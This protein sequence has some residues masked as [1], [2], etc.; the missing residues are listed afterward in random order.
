[1]AIPHRNPKGGKLLLAGCLAPGPP[2]RNNAAK[3]AAGNQPPGALCLRKSRSEKNLGRPV[4]LNGR[5][6][7]CKEERNGSAL[8]G[9]VAE[10]VGIYTGTRPESSTRKPQF[11]LAIE[12]AQRPPKPN[13]IFYD[14]LAVIINVSGGCA[15][16][17][18]NPYGAISRRKRSNPYCPCSST[19]MF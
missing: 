19:M 9:T 7:H 5:F 18:S 10:R 16:R 6:T 17:A 3:T 4:R 14:R 15:L 12:W 13:R 2:W 11:R 8:F 1:V